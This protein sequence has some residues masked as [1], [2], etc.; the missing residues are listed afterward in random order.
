MVAEMTNSETQRINIKNKL[1]TLS[2]LEKCE[3][4]KRLKTVLNSKLSKNKL[5]KQHNTIQESYQDE[6]KNRSKK[7]IKFVLFVVAIILIGYF[8]D[9][10]KGSDKA[11]VVGVIALTIAVYEIKKEIFDSKYLILYRNFEFEIDRYTND[12]NQYGIFITSDTDLFYEYDGS[13]EVFQNK[14]NEARIKARTELE[15][16]ILRCMNLEVETSNVN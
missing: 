2:I 14:F 1:E 4:E 9:N 5:K 7:E 6:L 3:F 13:N 11:Y 15:L 10:L 8:F 12:I 16:E